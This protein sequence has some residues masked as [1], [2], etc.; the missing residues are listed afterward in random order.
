VSGLLKIKASL[1]SPVITL[2]SEI[3]D[4]RGDITYQEIY[5]A[6]NGGMWVIIEIIK[7]IIKVVTFTI[8]CLLSSYVLL[9]GKEKT[10]IKIDYAFTSAILI[11]V[12]V[13][14]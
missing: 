2:Q 6:K 10:G 3:L 12:M 4:G 13:I 11:G 5:N 1:F 9:F 8:F 14:L 7:V